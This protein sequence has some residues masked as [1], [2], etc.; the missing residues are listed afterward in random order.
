MARLE[1][2]A[3]AGFYPTPP[4]EMEHIIKRISSNVDDVTLLDPCA[5][6]GLA[7][8][9]LRDHLQEQG[10]NSITYG[11]EL[12]ETRAEEAKKQLDNLLYVGFKKEII[13]I[14]LFSFMY[15]N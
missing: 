7:L 5:G 12:E 8:K 10:I 13:L 3:K 6:E 1:A 11:I 4:V 9:Q 2:D 15:F 14:N